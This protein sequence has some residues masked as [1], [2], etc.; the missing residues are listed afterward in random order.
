M[1]TNFAER[2]SVGSIP[3]EFSRGHFWSRA[4]TP[5]KV[6]RVLE[7]SPPPHLHSPPLPS[8]DTQLPTL[9]SVAFRMPRANSELGEWDERKSKRVQGRGGG[10]GGGNSHE[11]LLSSMD[12]H[13]L[14][15]STLDFN[16]LLC[17]EG[18]PTPILHHKRPD[19]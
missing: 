11:T 9:A 13:L 17:C 2:R 15:V 4:C 19:P 7:F 18:G 3:T 10:G 5:P 8:H 14:T 6:H 16:A 12:W 1:G